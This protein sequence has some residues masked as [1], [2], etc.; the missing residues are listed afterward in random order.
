MR[1]F[2]GFQIEF[3]NYGS[4]NSPENREL[5]GEFWPALRKAGLIVERDV[6]QLYDPRGRHVSGRS[7]RER[8]VSHAASRRTSTATTATSAAVDLQ[9]DRPDRPGQHAL[10]RQAGASQLAKHL[11]VEHRAAA[12]LPRRVDAI[13]R[14]PAA[15]GRQLPRRA[16][17]WTSRCATG[18][19]RGPRRTSASRFPTARATT[20]TSGSMRRS[21]T[22]PRTARVVPAAGRE[23]STT[24]GAVAQTRDPP[25]HRQGHHVLPHAVLARRCSRRPASSCRRRSTSTA[26]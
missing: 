20:G 24:G 6:T 9:P 5:C 16:T 11:F 2:A 19:S 26:F 17:S 4:T 10:G 12:R 14:P 1:D 13:G 23:A 18:T 25:L 8:D 15:G 3:D 22:W 7:V 21:A